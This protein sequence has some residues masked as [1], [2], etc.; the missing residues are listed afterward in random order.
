MLHTFELK[1]ELTCFLADRERLPAVLGDLMVDEANDV[2]PDG[3]LEDS[4][5]ADCRLGV[6]SL[7]VVD[8]NQR[9]SLGKILKRHQI[10]M[11][12]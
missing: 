2:G 11:I 4:R 10:K 9:T 3:G 7:L 12:S 5:K 8:G 1:I 6:V